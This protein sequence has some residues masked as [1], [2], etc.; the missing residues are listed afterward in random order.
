MGSLGILSDFYVFDPVAPGQYPIYRHLPH[1]SPP[2]WFVTHGCGGR[3][4][5]LT[6]EQPSNACRIAFVGASTTV[7]G[8]ALTLSHPEFVGFWLH[9][10]AA[11]RRLPYTFEV[12]N[13]GRTGIDSS[14][15]AALVRQEILAVDPDL[16]LY[17]EGANQ[18]APGKAMR[19]PA[20]LAAKPTMTF[21]KRTR[22][23]D[24]S[25]LVLR[26]LNLVSL[27]RG[28]DG[29]EPRKPSYPTIWPKDVDE[30]NPDV[31]KVPLPMDMDRVLA[32]FDVMRMSLQSAGSELA[33]SS[34]IWMVYPGMVLALDRHLTLYRFLN[35]TYWPATYAHLRRMADFQNRLFENYARRHDLAFT[36]VAS[37]FPRDPDL[38]GDA[39]HMTEDGLRLQAWIYLQQLVPIIRARLQSHR[40]PRPAAA[41]GSL[42]RVDYTPHLI[43]KE[44]IVAQ[45]H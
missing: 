32:N 34:F 25:A 1:V 17:Y 40:W 11:S 5:V 38:F 39:I 12:I 36:D 27:V 4:R 2:A 6:R 23:E 44:S 14:S 3:G 24:Y 7:D 10:W 41:A 29:A 20:T 42:P 35:D 37:V 16:V 19:L 28:G 13:A 43:S 30:R 31:T 45:C 18:F 15:I 21:R 33:L 8:F 9:R 22:A 26:L